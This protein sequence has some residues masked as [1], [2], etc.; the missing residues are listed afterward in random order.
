MNI[1]KLI[2]C[3]SVL[4]LFAAIGCSDEDATDYSTLVL[5]NSAA[6]IS[7]SVPANMTEQDTSFLL[8]VTVDPPQVV[9]IH[10]DLEQV[11]GSATL[12]EDFSFSE[13]VIVIPAYA[14][15]A[16][17]ELKIVSDCIDEET[18]T[19]QIQIGNAKTSNVTMTPQVLDISL[20]DFNADALDLTMDWAGS[21]EVITGQNFIYQGD[22]LIIDTVDVVV[23]VDFCADVDLDIY[24]FKDGADAG[25]YDAATGACPEHLSVSGW[26]DG[27]YTLMANL[28]STT[29]TTNASVSFPITIGYDRC[30]VFNGL[31]VN[32]ST[33][34]ITNLAAGDDFVPLAKVI[35]NGSDI[36]I[37][38]L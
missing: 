28:W 11:S 29:F 12:G 33:E 13:S 15:S 30:G 38:G 5:A 9:D 32:P 16:S 25:I 10:V 31:T 14:S 19:I 2:L 18:E 22:T 6:T 27:E 21:A 24:V 4:V 23:P 1:N 34:N 3:F 36:S 8:T 20:S 35:V 17:Q 7:A 37:E 26:E